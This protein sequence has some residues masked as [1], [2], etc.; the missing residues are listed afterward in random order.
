[1]AEKLQELKNMQC[2]D[3][4]FSYERYTE[5][6]SDNICNIITGHS[7]NEQKC[8]VWG[9]NHYLSLN[10][11]ES[12]LE[13][14]KK[15]IDKFGT[16]SGTS[17]VSGGMS[18]L[19]KQL[20]LRIAKMLNKEEV[21]LF[22]TGFTANSGTIAGLATNKSLFL[23]DREAHA[24]II[25]GCKTSGMKYTSFKHNNVKDLENKLRDYSADYDNIIVIVESAYSMSGELSPLKEIV[26]LKKKYHFYIIVDEAHS[27]GFYGEKGSGYC[28]ESGVSDD[29][30]FITGTLSKA[31]ASIGGYVATK[32]KFCTLIRYS[33]PAYLFQACTPPADIAVVLACLDEIE[34]NPGLIRQLHE[35]NKYFREKLTAAGF[36]LGKSESPIVPV[37]IDNLDALFHIEKELYKNGIF[38]V[39]VRYPAVKLHEGRLRFIVNVRHTK[40]QMDK[41][42]ECLVEAS[43]KHG[44]DVSNKHNK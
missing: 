11:N 14:A 38:T 37:Y 42:V 20:E 21:V 24:S 28:S 25:D 2:Q 27:F 40:E 33:C 8:I 35:N 6:G 4:L 15:A 32:E 43:K 7:G 17:A 18:A 12:V 3:D 10:R 5:C 26:A 39:A 30:D 44:F 36:Y 1:V 9:V 13:K 16:G 34:D 29:I 23:I 22:P 19:H 41:T 31:T